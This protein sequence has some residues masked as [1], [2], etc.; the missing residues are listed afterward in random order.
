[1]LLAAALGLLSIFAERES[2]KSEAGRRP[3]KLEAEYFI[4]IGIPEPSDICINPYTN[5]FYVVSDDGILFE[6]DIKGRPLR[7]AAFRGFDFEAVYADSQFVY[8]VEEYT[9]KIRLFDHKNLELQRTVHLPYSGGRNKSYES[10]TFNRATGRFVLLT[11]KDPIYLFELDSGFRIV[12]E[13][14]MTH[15]AS[16]ISAATYHDGYLWLL[17]DEDMHVIQ[18]DARSREELGRWYVPIIN[19]EGLAFDKEG[20]MLIISDDMERLYV[21]KDPRK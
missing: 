5:H 11:E 4:Q 2:P 10:F 17:S 15:L 3:I 20:N 19:P 14:D 8:V 7:E 18:L 1:M 21:F 6:M 9:R 16:D 12:N 13:W